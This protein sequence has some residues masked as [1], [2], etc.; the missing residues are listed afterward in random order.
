MK[1]FNTI[2]TFSV[3][4]LGA[5]ILAVTATHS[6]FAHGK[7]KHVQNVTVNVTSSGYSPSTLNLKAG[8]PVHLTFVSKGNSCANEISIPSLKKT[9][10]LKP[11]QKKEVTFTPKKGQTV[12]FACSMNMFKGKV[13]AK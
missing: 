4:S 5:G 3:L 1:K 12:A 11:G 6:A 10:S 13:A 9:F 7:D 2:V 8:R